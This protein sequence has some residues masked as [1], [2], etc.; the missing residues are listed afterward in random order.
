MKNQIRFVGLALL[1]LSIT[2]CQTVDVTKTGKGFYEPTTP[3]Q[4]EVLMTRPDRGY[5]ELGTVSTFNWP[6]SNTAK[7]HNALR[8]KTAPLGAHAVILTDTGVNPNGNMWANGV[9][10]R[11]R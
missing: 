2:A 6:R 10:I 11:Y 4:I 3:D 8:A 7:M 9:A 1:V 5:V